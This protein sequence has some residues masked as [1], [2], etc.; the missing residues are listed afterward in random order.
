MLN[1]PIIPGYRIV[2]EL[3]RGGV[4]TVWLA[5]QESLGREVA[6]KQLSSRLMENPE[7][8]ARFMREARIAAQLDHRN[9]VKVF[10]VGI[11]EERPF[12]A[13]ELLDCGAL[14]TGIAYP[15]EEAI[16]IVRDIALALDHAHAEGV[17][18]RD[19]KPENILRRKD[20]SHALADFGIA[21]ALN[22]GTPLT[23]P[24]DIVGTPE[25]MS[26]E[27]LTAQ[28]LDGR[29]D[30][31]S[32][33]VVLYQLLTAQLPFK[34]GNAMET[35]LLHINAPRPRLPESLERYQP[36]IDTLL[37]KRR[38]DRPSTG[39]AVVQLIDTLHGET[40]PASALPPAAGNSL[41]ALERVMALAE[42]DRHTD[43]QA[44]KLGAMTCA[45]VGRADLAVPLL[46]RLFELPDDG[47]DF[48]PEL[49]LREPV[50]DPIRECPGF[51]ELC[52][53][54]DAELALGM[55]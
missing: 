55:V 26:P 3:G 9:I 16:A 34:G 54:Y 8:A 2:R 22:A 12:L 39:A 27:Q 44:L 6:L 25:Y 49:L 28:P 33:G 10:D 13:I 24:G 43:P 21:R 20:G 50:W 52:R 11:H 7:A 41:M 38:E 45:A 31:Y 51:V 48:I 30:I 29:S 1:I 23:R 47:K 46:Q 53:R 17:I 36:L 5:V 40:V 35:G 4:A 37:A 19:L 15:P 18:H 14:A 32:L 42:A